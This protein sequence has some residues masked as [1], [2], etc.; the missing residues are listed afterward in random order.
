MP[1]PKP[2]QTDAGVPVKLPR[3]LLSGF[4]T[5]LISSQVQT[6]NDRKR[7]KLFRTKIIISAQRPKPELRV[8]PHYSSRPGNVT[9]DLVTPRSKL[10]GRFPGREQERANDCKPHIKH[11]KACCTTWASSFCVFMENTNMSPWNSYGMFCRLFPYRV[12]GQL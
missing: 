10:Q 8:L 4:T 11:S 6:W 5:R 7:E 3:C 2:A 1:R 12:S 9:S